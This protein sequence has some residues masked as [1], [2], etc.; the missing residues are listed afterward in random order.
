MAADPNEPSFNQVAHH[1]IKPV[2]VRSAVRVGE[3]N[4]LAARGQ[5]A[6][7]ARLGKA[8]IFP[9]LNQSHPGKLCRDVCG[10]VG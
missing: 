3:R 1:I 8:E 2:L 6:G 9:V 5:R 7:V 10:R 4:H